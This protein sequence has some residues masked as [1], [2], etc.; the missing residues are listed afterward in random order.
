MADAFAHRTR[1]P[2]DPA[3]TLFEVVPDDISDLE[4]VTTALNVATQ[5]RVRVTMA[6]G[7]E[8]TISVVPGVALPVRVRRVWATG[9]TAT[10]IMGLA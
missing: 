7:S 5:G 8:G 2:S 1:K 9:T 4:R 10:G 3:A 6:D